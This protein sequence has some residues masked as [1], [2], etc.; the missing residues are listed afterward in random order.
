V[1]YRC[2]WCSEVCSSVLNSKSSLPKIKALLGH[3]DAKT[4]VAI[5]AVLTKLKDPEGNE[6]Y[7]EIVTGQ[8]KGGGS[9]LDGI[10]DKKALETMGVQS[11]IGFLPGGGE[12]TGAYDY[13]KRN[14]S[15]NAALDVTAVTALAE[16]PDPEVKKAL[17]QAC[18]GGKEV[19]EA[20]ALRALAKRGD[21]SVIN[22]IEPAMYSD[23]PLVRYTAAAAI[24]HLEDVR[25]RQPGKHERNE[26]RHQAGPRRTSLG[27]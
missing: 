5:A 6:I 14:G 16:D 12:A 11:A 17:V 27:K 4:V 24:V 21:P 18:F 8:R 13:L 2:E 1:I 23:N 15:A 25:A 19:V 20:A 26:T 22:E 10:K 9:I 3:A 7:Y